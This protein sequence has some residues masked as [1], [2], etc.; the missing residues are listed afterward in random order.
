MNVSAQPQRRT[1]EQMA[2]ALRLGRVFN[3]HG[4][5][6][7]EEAA[8]RQHV[9]MELG[10]YMKFAHY[11]TA[12]NALKII[13]TKRLWMR[14]TTCME[15]YREVRHGYDLLLKYFNEERTN[16]FVEAF[17]QSVPGAARKAID[18]F[19]GWWNANHFLNV[20]V[21]SFSEH[22]P[23]DDVHGRLSMWRAFGTSKNARVALIFRLPYGSFITDVLGIIFSP[24]A[25]LTE[26]QLF[27][28][29]DQVVLRARAE[30]DFLAEQPH[31]IV[32]R[33]LIAMFYIGVSC[34][35]HEGFMEER[36]WRAV[37]N[38]EM[39]HS[40]RMELSVEAVGGVPQ[41]VHKMPLDR[42]VDASLADA[43][44][45]T[46]LDG[47]IIGPSQYPWVIHRA[48]GDEL[49]KLGISNPYD[50]VRASLIPIRS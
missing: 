49:G 36:E 8:E 6:Q 24:V 40:P 39:W 38:P 4:V 5:R 3:P 34:V 30:R 47:V 33:L 35:K 28:N 25:Y 50:R 27:A 29:I 15:D 21:T 23:E 17:D 16:T 22:A 37:Y 43:D 9:K 10:N 7:R 44:L 11:T 46:I 19:N 45:G 14:N 32:Q 41:H 31:D 2:T 20:Y 12:E 26:Q 18:I 42:T 48:F 13:R 1:A